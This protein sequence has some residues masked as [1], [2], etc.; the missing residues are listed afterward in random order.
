MTFKQKLRLQWLKLLVKRK[1]LSKKII[2]QQVKNPDANQTVDCGSFIEKQSKIGHV[3]AKQQQHQISRRFV[4]AVL[5]SGKLVIFKY[6][7]FAHFV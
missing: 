5:G 6:K 2:N 7:R 4:V 3:S 1:K